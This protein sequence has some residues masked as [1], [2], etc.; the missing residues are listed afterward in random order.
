MARVKSVK[1]HD[2]RT[3]EMWDLCSNFLFME[4][5]IGKNR[6]LASVGKLQELNTSVAIS[7]WTTKISKEKLSQFQA[8]V[9]IGLSLK[10]KQLTLMTTI[11]NTNHP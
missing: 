9:F 3:I 1:L 8:V 5:D 2:E 10:K 4:D 11:V 6:A 7:T